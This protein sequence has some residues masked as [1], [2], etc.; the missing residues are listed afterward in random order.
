MKLASLRVGAAHHLAVVT[1]A[2]VVDL[3]ATARQI[4]WT[5]FD[6]AVWLDPV[7]LLELGPAALEAAADLA[8]HGKPLPPEIVRFGAPI[9]NPRKLLLLAGNYAEHILESGRRLAEA[10]QVTPRV[11]MKPPSTTLRG[12]FDAIPI[13]P[14][15][16]F[17]DWEAELAVV[18]GRRC[19]AVRAAEA[20][21]CVAGYLVL[22][23]ISERELLLRERPETR[24]IDEF[25]DWLNGKWLDGFAPCGPWLTTADEVPD[26]HALPLRLTVNGVLHQDG[27]TGQM[28]FHV[29]EIIEWIS[30]IVTLEPGDIIATG[31]CAG[32][33]RAKGVRL[34]PGDVVRAEVGHLGALENLCVAAE[35]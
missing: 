4:G 27:N 14:V 2:G 13:P 3:A 21:A 35:K 15:A 22:N 16:R 33:G 10:D 29:P 32:V 20:A 6:E 17:V 5:G 11:F 8:N 9:P 31:T 7:K 18:I 1:A 24:P 25:F 19:K 26:P 34:R 12:P 30:T 28:I 23:D